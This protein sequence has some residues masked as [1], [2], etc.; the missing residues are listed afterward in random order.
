M[1]FARPYFLAVFLDYE[2]KA[3]LKKTLGVLTGCFRPAIVDVEVRGAEGLGRASLLGLHRC[4][5][6]SLGR[7]GESRVI[8]YKSVVN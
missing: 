4:K 2:E 7:K 1:T 8:H 6:S 5:G 3:Y